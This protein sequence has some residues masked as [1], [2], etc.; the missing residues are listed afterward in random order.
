MWHEGSKA[1]EPQL[2]SIEEQ[3]FHE[4]IVYSLLCDRWSLRLNTTII[5]EEKVV[6]C[7]SHTH[8]HTQKKTVLKNIDTFFDKY[9]KKCTN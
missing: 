9:P 8:T 4:Q 7:C 2:C 5:V 1:G 6:G 3:S